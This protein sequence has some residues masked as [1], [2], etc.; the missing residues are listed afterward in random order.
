M[1]ARGLL[2]FLREGMETL[3]YSSTTNSCVT[4]LFYHSHKEIT[5]KK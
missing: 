3:P 5:T 1:A 2:R 4:R